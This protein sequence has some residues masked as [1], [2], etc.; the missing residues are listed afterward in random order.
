M[1]EEKEKQEFITDYFMQ[2]FTSNEN[3]DYQELLESVPTRV[4]REMN[5]DLMKEFTAEEIKMALDAIGDLKAPSSDG[6]PSVFYK[7]FWDL[8]GDQVTKEVMEVLNGGPMPERWNETVIALIPKVQNPEKVTDLRPISLCNVLYKIV[9][10]VLANRLKSI[11]PDIISPNQSA[12]IPGRLISD[13]ILIAYEMTHYLKNKREG[14]TGY[15]AI[16]LDMSKAYD[17]VEWQFLHDM[18][19]KM[20][21]DY[22]W[23]QLMMNCVSTVSYSI[24]I[25]GDL[26]TRFKPQRGL[27]QGDPLSPYLFL[28][29]AEDFSA[30]LNRAEENGLISGVMICPDAPSVSHLLFADDSLILIRATE[31]DAMQSQAILDLFEQCSGQVINKLK[32]AVLFST[33]THNDKKKAVRNVLGVERETMNEKYLGLPVFVGRKKSTIFAY[34]KDRVWQRIQGWKE[35]ALSWAGKEILIKAIAQAIP[36]FAMGCFDLT[37]T[38]CDQ[39]STLICR[40]WWNQQEGEHKIH[41]ISWKKMILPKKLGGLGFRDI[42]AFNLAMLSKQGW[43]LIQDPDSLC[44]RILKAKYFPNSSCL[45]A[46]P[47]SGMSY[48]W[49]SILR[50]IEL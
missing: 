43:R 36:T 19:M 34:L 25:N 2:L 22:R 1:E 33:N 9:S 5:D 12:F 47:K 16:K 3:G 44:A 17:R 39:I 49:R 7:Q 42:Y 8:V 13:N 23:V 11:L 24:K 31:G 48:S 45:E 18:M 21:F 4:S 14:R 40:Y 28:L 6:L 41:W 20:G 29:C 37:K 15:A 27:R 50:G 38:I 32:S 35:K 10:K 26:S 46:V 30:L